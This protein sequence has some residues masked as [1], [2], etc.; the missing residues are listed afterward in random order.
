MKVLLIG[1]GYMAREYAKVLQGLKLPF[2]VVGRG[3]EKSLEFKALYKD[4]PVFEGGLEHF[5]PT[6]Q[7]TH[8]IVSSNVDYL[9]T[10]TRRLIDLG[11]KNILLEKPGGTNLKEIKDVSDYASK[12]NA[13]VII[14]YNRRFYASVLKCREL[15]E[16]DGGVTSFNFEFTEWTSSFAD[17]PDN[18]VVKNNL[19]FANS[20]HVIDLAFFL[21][22]LPLKMSS[23]SSGRL[24]WHE[25]AIYSGAG[26]SEK[27]ALFSYQANWQAPGRWSVEMLT[28]EHRFV[29][30]PMEQLQIQKINSVKIEP[31]ELD[32]ALDKQYKPGLFRQTQAFFK[33]PSDPGL[34]TI[35]QQA[36]NCG[37]YQQIL[38]GN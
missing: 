1:T 15:L 13:R 26:K 30:R 32:D 11:I 36:L 9:A 38:D 29:F 19:L 7:Y 28:K 8:G 18:S 37:Y 16:A 25:K 21:G 34:L 14:A 3:K 23:F 35:Q 20:T 27:G 17:L 31:Y 5:K 22:G 6:G 10:H 33:D 2:D 12:N 4:V 24:D